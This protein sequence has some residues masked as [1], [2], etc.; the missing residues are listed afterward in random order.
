MVLKTFFFNIYLLN[1]NLSF[2]LL[3]L[4]IGT[5]YKFLVCSF[6]YKFTFFI[7]NVLVLSVWGFLYNLDGMILI[8]LITEFTVT[9]LFL[10][11]YTQLYMHY[12]FKHKTMPIGLFSYI[13]LFALLCANPVNIFFSYTSFYSSLTHL[14]SSDFFILYYLLFDKMPILVLFLTL[15]ISLFSLFFIL[16]YFNLKYTKLAHHKNLKNLYILRKQNLTKQ[17]NFKTKIYTFQN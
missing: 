16:L 14:V 6:R 17:T 4:L 8:L 1:T 15:I 3:L 2:Y 5:A 13:M 11:T 10:M 7:L 12:E 9:L